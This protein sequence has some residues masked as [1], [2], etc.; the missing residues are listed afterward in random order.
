MAFCTRIALARIQ[1]PLSPVRRYFRLGMIA[2]VVLLSVETADAQTR[3]R[4]LGERIREGVQARLPVAPL[5]PAPLGRGPLTP[6]A[7]NRQTP[8]PTPA[9]PP[10]PAVP[11]AVAR[12]PANRGDVVRSNYNSANNRSA[13]NQ[14]AQTSAIADSGASVMSA[15]KPSFASKARLGVT[16]E[17]PSQASS[18]VRSS[19][20]ARG[21]QVVGVG[22]RSGAEAAGVQIGDMIVA[23]DGRMV[24]SVDAF[25]ARLTNKEP[26]D[27]VELRFIRDQRLQTVVAVMAGPDGRLNDETYAQQ[28]RTRGPQAPGLDASSIEN[29]G[30]T[31]EKTQSG[32]G[33]LGRVVGGWLGGGRRAEGQPTSA[34]EGSDTIE[35]E[36][37]PAPVISEDVQP[38]IV[39][40]A[41]AEAA[42]ERM[43][44]DYD[45]LEAP[46]VPDSSEE[47]LLP[48]PVQ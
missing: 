40:E 33:G 43:K 12:Q 7:G 1:N 29:S 8:S 4:R 27:R 42:A 44:R 14:S 21:A 13:Y 28:L 39:E 45:D 22:E 35:S 20:P 30:S 17:T 48:P 36:E 11:A 18:R 25:V 16:V 15:A 2:A 34:P 31:D 6:P 37:L 3:I 32:L 26:G 38:L 9:L 19:R 23:I 46:N 10:R 24:D 41:N 47:E 5:A